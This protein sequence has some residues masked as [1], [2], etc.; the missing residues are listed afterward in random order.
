MSAIDRETVARA[1]LRANS[2]CQIGGDGDWPRWETLTPPQQAKFLHI[3]DA[4][5]A[6]M[7]NPAT[8]AVPATMADGWRHDI[9][10]T[11]NRVM[12]SWIAAGKTPIEAAC[13][14]IEALAA[15][16]CEAHPAPVAVPEGW[17]IERS[18]A[19][20]DAISVTAPDCDPGSMVMFYGGSLERRLLYR[21]CGSLLAAAQGKD[22][23]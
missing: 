23:G 12:P 3:A 2:Q 9:C 17:V 19:H 10:T 8:V 16:A 22:N 21:L 14:A 11:L 4:A 20:P 7:S 5:I 13:N 18:P 15:V 1:M 6:A